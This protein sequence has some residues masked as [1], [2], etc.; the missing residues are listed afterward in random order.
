[1]QAVLPGYAIVIFPGTS[2]LAMK[3]AERTAAL[4]SG[5]KRAGMIP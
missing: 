3:L 4:E 2:L 5:L 1:M